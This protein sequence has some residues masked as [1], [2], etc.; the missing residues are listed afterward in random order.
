MVTFK[1][2]DVKLSFYSKTGAL[3]E[4]DHEVVY[5]SVNPGGSAGFKTKYFAPKGTDSV[6]MKVIS[7]KYW[8][9]DLVIDWFEDLEIWRFEDELIWR[10]GDL[11]IWRLF[12]LKIVWFGDELTW[13]LF[14]DEVKKFD[15]DYEYTWFYF[16]QRT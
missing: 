4:E 14:D 8:F 11:K 9:V 7:A 12:D 15:V 13:R 2:I 10:F 16:I 1:D 5:E 6:A 3:L